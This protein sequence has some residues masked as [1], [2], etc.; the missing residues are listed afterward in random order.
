MIWDRI[1]WNPDKIKMFLKQYRGFRVN[2]AYVAVYTCISFSYQ[3]ADTYVYTIQEEHTHFSMFMNDINLLLLL[4]FVFAGWCTCASVVF[5][6]HVVFLCKQCQKKGNI[7]LCLWDKLFC[8]LINIFLPIIT[9]LI[10]TINIQTIISELL[11]LH[12]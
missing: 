12:N 5:H 8:H 11:F 7:L 9:H 1:I 2:S 6:V 10:N 3:E 4:V